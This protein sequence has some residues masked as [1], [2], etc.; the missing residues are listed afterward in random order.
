MLKAGFARAC[1]TPHAPMTLAGF[2]R[3]TALSEGVLDDLYVSVLA[4]QTGEELPFLLCTFDLL[5]TDRALCENLRRALPLPPERVWIC[6]THTHSAPRGAFSGGISQDDGYISLL[7]NACKGAALSALSDLLPAEVLQSA[8][9]I[10]RIASL[11]DVPRSQADYAMPLFALTFCRPADRLRLVGIR[12]HPTVLDEHNLKITRDLA[13]FVPKDKTLVFNGAC[14][15]LSTRFTRSMSS[16]AELERLRRVLRRGMEALTDA[17]DPACG[18]RLC[19]ASQ[20]LK[21]PYG[22]ILQGEARQALLADLKKQAAAC[23]D[24]AARRELDSCIAVLERGDRTLPQSRTV[25]VSACD[26]GSCLLLALPFEVSHADG[27]RLTAD[28]SARC[29]KPAHLICYC[30]GYDGY[31]PHETQGINYQDLATGYPLQARDLIWQAALDCAAN[32]VK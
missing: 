21:L 15:D 14:A 25:N 9:K 22:S 19:T 26:L 27:D 12:C 2:D 30:G 31:L 18:A 1:I 20:E 11:R 13:G 23:P 4:L 28:V 16:E 7:I 6:A 10:P 32:A 5:G 29:G 24:P 17:P 8:G 3:R